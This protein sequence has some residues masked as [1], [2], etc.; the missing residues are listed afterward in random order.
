MSFRSEEAH[1]YIHTRKKTHTHARKRKKYSENRKDQ[2]RLS[3]IPETHT[4]TSKRGKKK[5]KE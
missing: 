3:S 1:T 5:I 2:L 4:H